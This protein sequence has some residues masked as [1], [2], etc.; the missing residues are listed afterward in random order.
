MNYK[1]IYFQI[2]RNRRNNPLPPEEYGE[3]H[4]IIPR[5]FCGL[6]TPENL[7]RLSAREHFIVHFL[8]YKIYKHRVENVFQHSQREKDRFRKMTLAFNLMINTKTKLQKRLNKN[9]NSHVFEQLRKAVSKQT[10]KYPFKLV[11]NMFEF[12][13][14]NNLSTRT[15]DVLN[16]QFNTNFKSNALKNLFNRNNLKING[17]K[18]NGYKSNRYKRYCIS[19]EMIVEMF[20]FYIKNKLSPK[21]IDVLNK[22]F[23]TDF[24][25]D[26][27]KGL[28]RKHNLKISAYRG[29]S[30]S[31]DKYSKEMI[32]E[33]FDFYIQNNL[34]PKT[35]HI[36]NEKFKQNFT[37][38]RLA[39]LFRKN[40]LSI[41]E[42]QT[43]TSLFDFERRV[44]YLLK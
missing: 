5:S 44:E 36:L 39:Y 40:N 26:V 7:V 9:I 11:R 2:I 32:V 15:I 16:K 12:Y 38:A 1:K 30:L 4:H 34:S 23:N 42:Y 17:H 29:N 20:D 27:L 14:Q 37:Y 24:T 31:K 28:F 41:S 18:S 21:T 35:I 43:R 13:I 10:T 33:M 25:Y 8:L 22:Q 19:K 6:D 3:L